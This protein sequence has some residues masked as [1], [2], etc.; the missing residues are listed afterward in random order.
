[1]LVV[2]GATLM[3][4][5]VFLDPDQAPEAEQLVALLDD[6]LKVV[7]SPALMLV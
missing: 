4:P 3:L 2:V 1:L 6:Q 7:D 5:L